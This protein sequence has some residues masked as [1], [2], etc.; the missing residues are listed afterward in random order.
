[1][2][3]KGIIGI[4]IPA[5]IL[6]VWWQYNTK[7]MNKLTA[8]RAAQQA[9]QAKAAEAEAKKTAATNAPAGTPPGTPAE[10]KS[11]TPAAPAAP[12]VPEKTDTLE[13]ESV[14]YTF[15]TRGAGIAKAL[16]KK[17][18]A[19]HGT[20]MTLNEFGEIPIG[21]VTDAPGQ[22]SSVPFHFAVDRPAGVITFEGSDER[23]LHLT[24]KFNVPKST[25]L[26]K[27][28]I[29]TMRLVFDNRS[30]Q[31]ITVPAY[32][33]YTGSAAPVHQRDLPTYTGFK[34]QG[35]KFVD[36]GWFGGGMFK[37][38]QSTYTATHDAIPWAA[39]ADQYFTTIIS[40]IVDPESKID[41]AKQRGDAVWAERFQITDEQWK[42][43]DHSAEG[44]SAARYGME[45]ALGMPGF[46]LAPGQ[47]YIQSFHIYTGPREYGRLRLMP[48]EEVDVLAFSDF[49]G[50]FSFLG[51]FVGFF[52]KVLLYSLNSLHALVGSYAIAIIII[53]LVI[54][55]ILWP[56]QNKATKAAKRM[57]AL[58]PK[59]TE[60]REKYKDDPQKMNAEVMKLYKEYGVNPLAGC[61]PAFIQMPIFFGFYNMLGKAVELRNAKFLW[62]QDLSQPDTLFHIPGLNFPVNILPIFM[63]VTMVWQMMASPKTGDPQQQKI[64]MIMPLIFVLFCYNYASALALYLTVNN[65]VSVAQLY[66]TRN[67]ALPTLQKPPKKK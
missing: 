23:G 52:S 46:T 54:K 21:S 10:T 15:T 56:M 7:E 61:W 5:I 33:V 53:T 24:K 37:K 43:T 40:P 18:E 19:E 45:G 63:A 39:V 31:P 51:P 12:A 1:M 66:A 38:A 30:Q 2:D 29:V 11:A 60:V 42:Q 35:G 25:N 16:L 6:L 49:G 50:I 59:M 22:I 26:N 48:N 36:V 14:D 47:M 17:H 41:P 62:V 20:R 27:D 13:T 58:S 67:Q 8:A 3:R 9:E 44:S 4:I 65:L 64:M 28:Y 34:W 57:Q 55:A 32:Y